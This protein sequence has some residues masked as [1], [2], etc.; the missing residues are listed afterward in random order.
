MRGAVIGALRWPLRRYKCGVRSDN[1]LL[2]RCVPLR[3]RKTVHKVRGSRSV[4]SLCE[5][6]ATQSPDEDWGGRTKSA[7]LS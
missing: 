5:D 7:C 4:S 3:C 2:T 6:Q 1:A